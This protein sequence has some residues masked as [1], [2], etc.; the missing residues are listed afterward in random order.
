MIYIG[1]LFINEYWHMIEIQV[2]SLVPKRMMYRLGFDSIDRKGK[3]HLMLTP[4]LLASERAILGVLEV[5]ESGN[6]LYCF[7]KVT[8]HQGSGNPN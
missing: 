3:L 5:Q 1:Y 2:H 8:A 6:V 7:L 4:N